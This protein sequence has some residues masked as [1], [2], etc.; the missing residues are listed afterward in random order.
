MLHLKFL[1]KASAVFLIVLGN[2]KKSSQ[3]RKYA[4]IKQTMYC[5]YINI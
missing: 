5:F 2:S 3:R 4:F 1:Q